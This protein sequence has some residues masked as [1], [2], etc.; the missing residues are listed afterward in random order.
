MRNAHPVE[1]L[2]AA[3]GHGAFVAKEHTRQHRPGLLAHAGEDALRHPEPPAPDHRTQP[4]MILRRVADDLRQAAEF[5]QYPL[6]PRI[7]GA[8]EQIA[9]LLA[10]RCAA[11]REGIAIAVIRRLTEQLDLGRDCSLEAAVQVVPRITAWIDMHGAD[12]AG[13]GR[14][15]PVKRHL[16]GAVGCILR[17]IDTARRQT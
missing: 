7:G 14:F 6:R 1:R 16:T 15:L 4:R 5:Q 11:E 3:A 8:V 2:L 9:A 10:L 13:E 12:R 17:P